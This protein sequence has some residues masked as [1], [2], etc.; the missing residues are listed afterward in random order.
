MLYNKYY[1]WE[2]NQKV[3]E[4][5]DTQHKIISILVPASRL[6]SSLTKRLIKLLLTNISTNEFICYYGL[7]II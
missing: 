6:H 5:H 4:R 2:I 1:F 7:I 3:F